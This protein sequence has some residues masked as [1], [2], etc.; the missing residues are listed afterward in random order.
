MIDFNAIA[1]VFSVYVVGVVIPGPNFVGIAHR[2]ASGTTRE[3]L[4]MVGGTVLVNLFWA[5]CAILG[6]G[7]VFAT[8]PWIALAVKIVG[9]SYLIWFGGRLIVNARHAGADSPARG[10]PGGVARAF[11]AG[12]VTNIGNPKAMAFYAAVFSAA[13][14]RHVSLPTFLCMLGVVAVVASLWYGFVAVVFSTPAVAARYRR[15]KA[16]IDRVC[17]AVIVSLGV[18]QLLVR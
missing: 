18:R 12:I 13:A 4:A 1:L 9:A 5:S 7:V 17:G 10:G 3:A 15:G 16:W 2:A 11:R 6:I 14:P 8:F